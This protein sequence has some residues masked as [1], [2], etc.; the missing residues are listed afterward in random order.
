MKRPTSAVNTG[1]TTGRQRNGKAM[2]NGFE[3][4]G[5]YGFYGWRTADV[6]D[7]YGI[8]PRGYYDLLSSLWCADTCAPRMRGDWTEENRT[9]GQC[10]V[11]AFLLQ[12]IYGG[13]V[14]GVPLGDGNFHCFNDVGGCV[15]DLTSE[16]F[17]STV[18]SYDNCPEQERG[19]HF[20]KEEKKRRY[21]KLKA[22]LGAAM[23]RMIETKRLILRPFFPDDAEDVYGYLRDPGA[24]CFADMRL[25]SPEEA[26][27]ETERRQAEKE[28][29]LAIVLK[30]TGRVIGEIFGH[31]EGMFPGDQTADTFSPCWM[32]DP[33]YSGKGYAFEAARA[34]FDRL[35]GEK[36]I[37]RVY[38]Y[39][40]DTN[41]R[42]RRL[43]EKLGMRQEGLF[44]E[45]VSFTSGP[46]GKP[47]YENTVQ[48]AI[49]KREW[50]EKRALP[51]R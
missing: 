44:L 23:P 51:D 30:E 26:R 43:C 11:T 37:R 34:Y 42:S 24:D 20:S 9:L 36:G 32:L 46:D 5:N 39:T 1:S 8:T 50:E 18:L 28:Y 47:A 10:S 45:H 17:G 41:L 35:F 12:D 7:R 48:Y 3:N 16:Q 33:A 25:S 2:E 38:A 19:V 22:A 40:A 49:L 29:C 27:A 6:R 15:F 4:I 31:P 13:K 21:E 14:Y